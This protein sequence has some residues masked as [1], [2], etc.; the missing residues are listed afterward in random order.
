M[1]QDL[2]PSENTSSS[3]QLKENNKLKVA[4]GVTLFCI[5]PTVIFVVTFSLESI[6]SIRPH[7][8]T[9][10]TMFCYGVLAPSIFFVINEKLSSFAKQLIRSCI[11]DIF[12]FMPKTQ[13]HPIV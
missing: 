8:T 6:D 7:G 4:R 12:R 1:C 13:I 11:Q 10:F 5:L 2:G 9:A 3:L